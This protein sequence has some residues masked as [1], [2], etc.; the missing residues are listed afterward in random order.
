MNSNKPIQKLNLACELTDRYQRIRDYFPNATGPEL[1]QEWRGGR[2]EAMRRLA[3]V[4]G[5]HYGKTRNFLEGNVT[6]LSPYLRHGCI[7]LKEAVESVR[8]S[9]GKRAEKLLFEFAWRDYWH[10]VWYL[11][12]DDILSDM[13]PAKVAL[14]RSALPE[15]I[16]N[17]QT[18]LPCMDGFIS[19]L[20]DTGYVHNHARMW[21]AAYAVHWCKVDWRA[22]ADWYYAHLLDGDKASNSLS[23]QWVASTFGSKPYFFN[24]EN[25]AKYTAERYCKNCTAKCPFD[26]TYEALSEELFDS[27][28]TPPAKTYKIAP[29]AKVE[30]TQGANTI[31]LVHDEMLS[32]AHPL[33]RRLDKKI[34]VF[35]PTLHGDW[36]LHRLQFVADCLIEMEDVEIWFGDT[37]QVLNQLGAGQVI[38]QATPNPTIHALLG[39]YKVE[40]L[41]EDPLADIKLTSSDLRRFSKYWQ[42]MG[43]AILNPSL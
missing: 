22:A 37:R 35:D 33:L 40:Y 42:K 3:A 38:T 6:R 39:A 15:D 21:F 25:L 4:N 16:K 14:G 7:T 30:M 28:N 2:V 11:K 10:Q 26:N 12:G 34:F 24:K 17:G 8:A 18:G 41:P 13:E 27:T 20:L 29:L 31:V 23:L 32:P 36:A 1:R 9:F 43:P 5:D 19:D